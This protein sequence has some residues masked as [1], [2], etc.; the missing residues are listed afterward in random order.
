MI[1]S[2]FGVAADTSIEAVITEAANNSRAAWLPARYRAFD[3]FLLA[4]RG[5][6]RSRIHRVDR[7]SRFTP[8]HQARSPHFDAACSMRLGIRLDFSGARI[9]PAAG[10][11]IAPDRLLHP[12]G[13]R[14][15]APERT[16]CV[17]APEP[18]T[19]AGRVNPAPVNRPR[20]A[21]RESIA[22]RG[23]VR[24]RSRRFSD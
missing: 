20:G 18:A 24:T 3:T 15:T 21:G 8:T 9:C 12:R 19:R 1:R 5:T 14:A 17:V 13:T 7:R 16:E 22:A 23:R 11:G 2:I 6:A 4:L 10:R